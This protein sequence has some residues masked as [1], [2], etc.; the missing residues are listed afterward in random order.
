MSEQ[1]ALCKPRFLPDLHADDNAGATR[2][3]VHRDSQLRTSET[4]GDVLGRVYLSL[5]SVY[6]SLEAL[7]LVEIFRLHRRGLLRLELCNQFGRFDLGSR[8]VL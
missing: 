3:V 1:K 7:G 6:L 4:R 5:G 2:L 8:R